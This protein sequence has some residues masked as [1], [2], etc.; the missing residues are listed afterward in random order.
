MELIMNRTLGK[1]ILCVHGPACMALDR[2]YEHI[3]GYEVAD[4]G[5][6]RLFESGEYLR[7]NA[8]HQ[9]ILAKIS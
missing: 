1:T 9:N 2:V 5:Y 8:M 3:E 4:A 7:Q 6:R